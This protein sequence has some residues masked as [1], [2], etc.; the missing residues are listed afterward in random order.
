MPKRRPNQ[1][2]RIKLRSRLSEAQNHRCAYC[3]CDIRDSAT[4]DHLQA[5]SQ[6]GR[7][8][9]DNCVAACPKCNMER[10][11]KNPQRFWSDKQKRE[12]RAQ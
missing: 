10:D 8:D 12:A 6:G 11:Q 7:A 2:K 4:I 1:R 3:G 9:Y 5:H